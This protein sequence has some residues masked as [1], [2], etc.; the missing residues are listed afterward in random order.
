M[1]SV[2]ILLTSIIFQ[3][4][5][6]LT[7]SSLKKNATES[8]LFSYLTNDCRYN[9]N[10]RPPS[11]SSSK[12]FDV[13]IKIYVYHLKA[14]SKRELDIEIQMLLEMSWLDTRLNYS[15]LETGIM[16]LMGEKFL[17]DT[18]WVPHIYLTNEKDSAVMG[19]LRKDDLISIS[20][21]GFVVF[22]TR[23]R[24]SLTCQLQLEK[25]PFDQQSCQLIMDSWRYNS[26][27]VRLIWDD[28]SPTVLHNSEISLA[29]FYLLDMYTNT[30]Y[31]LY[32]RDKQ[33]YNYSSLILTFKLA[34]EYGF[35]LMDY[36]VPSCLLVILS[37][38]TFWL[39]PDAIPPRVFLGTSTMLT[40]LLLSWTGEAVP[41]VSQFKVNDIW[42]LSCTAFIFMSLTEF[43]FVNTIDRREKENIRLKK[44][45]GKYIL[46][47][48]VS[49]SPK[50]PAPR[51]QRRAS[52]CPSS[53]EIRRQFSQKYN[54]SLKVIEELKATDFHFKLRE[55][56]KKV[57][58]EQDAG[59][60]YTMTPQQI[61]TWIDKKSQ[62]MFPVMFII[63]NIFYWGI[64]L[65]PPF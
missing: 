10:E 48:S 40:F 61:A 11:S 45:S 33:T 31:N 41:K 32:E 44:R 27:E 29:E 24:T 8:E 20:P 46:K 47:Y 16:N 4:T 28:K 50:M 9:K 37:W 5:N 49:P 43:A 15:N 54:S 17:L 57:K 59:I 51:M 63:F 13:K 21:S 64:I 39:S 58:E 53:P 62:F 14:S 19:F 35:Y 26:S 2:Y 1:L 30:S 22:T 18:I 25:F 6:C 55:E 3:T 60:E 34:R 36:Y 56:L 12:L 42:E 52:S 7:C 65:I 38:V 23:L